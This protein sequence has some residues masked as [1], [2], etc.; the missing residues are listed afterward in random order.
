MKK[1]I[2]GRLVKSKVLPTDVNKVYESFASWMTV[3]M[4]MIENDENDILYI[5]NF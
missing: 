2:Y 5:Q 4:P 3:S 1:T